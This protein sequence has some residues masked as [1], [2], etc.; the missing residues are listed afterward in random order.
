MAC[1]HC[2][3]FSLQTGICVFLIFCFLKFSE[4]VFGSVFL[5]F[6]LSCFDFCFDICEFTI[7]VFLY[8]FLNL[9]ENLMIF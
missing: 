2:R 9:N 4:S 8:F 1:I 5:N 6:L 3:D 7:F